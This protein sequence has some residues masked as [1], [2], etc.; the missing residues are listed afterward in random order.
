MNLKTIKRI[1]IIA[2]CILVVFSLI[3]S[4]F[5]ADGFANPSQIIKSSFGGSVSGTGIKTA[6]DASIKIISTILSIIRTIAAGIAI[7][8]LIVIACKYILASAGDRAD[9][10]KYAVNYVIGALILFAASAIV[11]IIKQAVDSSLDSTPAQ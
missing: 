7:V 1:I 2:S 8:V 10:K 4:V 9:I 3:Y 5:A 6:A 11:E